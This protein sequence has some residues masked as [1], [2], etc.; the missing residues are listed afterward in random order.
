[1]IS[2]YPSPPL[3]SVVFVCLVI[4]TKSSIA[5]VG[6][7]IMALSLLWLLEC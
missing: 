4:E 3:H 2:Y 7:S 5:Q 6:L 1:M